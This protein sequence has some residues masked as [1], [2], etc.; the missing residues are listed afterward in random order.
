MIENLLLGLPGDRPGG[1][2]LTL[3]FALGASA[4]ALVTGFLYAAIC[5]RFPRSTFALQAASAFLRGVPLLLLIFFLA[6]LTTL[7]AGFAGLVALILYSFSHIGEVLRSYLAAYPTEL[8]AQARVVGIG[9]VQ[10][11][12]TLRLPWA[13]GRSFDAL[14]THWVSLLKDTGA[15]VVLGV[16]ELTTVG[17]VLGEGPGGQE[18]WLEVMLW[19]SG[20]YLLATVF[21]LA[22]LHA[23][24]RLAF[25]E[26]VARS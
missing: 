25:V 23:G 8:A 16:G 19:G 13:F 5:V 24:R 3:L 18:R 12:L 26:G 7:P 1:L 6:Q 10:E 20:F 11:W 21:L 14:G 9:P 2:L 22:A 17:K 15:L 4:G